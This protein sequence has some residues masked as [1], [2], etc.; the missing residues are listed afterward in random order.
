VCREAINIFAFDNFLARIF[1]HFKTK[2]MKNKFFY[3]GLFALSLIFCTCNKN[4]KTS[5]YIQ[6]QTATFS[7]SKK[8]SSKQAY[9]LSDAPETIVYSLLDGR[10]KFETEEDFNYF[11]NYL[12]EDE[13]TTW[14]SSIG[15]YSLY[16]TLPDE[17][18]YSVYATL[19]THGIIQ[20]GHYLFKLIP[21]YKK[22]LVMSD[23]NIA[24]LYELE[25]A[26]EGSDL[27]QAFSFNEEVFGKLEEQEGVYPT[28]VNIEK[29][30][31]RDRYAREDMKHG[32]FNYTEAGSYFRSGDATMHT[33]EFMGL[34]EYKKMGIAVQLVCKYTNNN[35]TIESSR[36]PFESASLKTQKT[37]FH[38]VFKY[39]PRCRSNVSNEIDVIYSDKKN[40]VYNVYSSTRDCKNYSLTSTFSFQSYYTSIWRREV[41]TINI[42]D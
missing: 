38:L 5:K 7:I 18:K 2:P 4:T 36:R 11:I 31:C 21:E 29:A 23:V 34:V 19:N 24:H 40:G 6:K 3:L 28:G 35:K 10:L 32:T 30:I 26:S 41:F 17:E 25:L 27:I 20:V 8:N 13:I 1:I 37:L 9:K 39:S 42:L 22:V 33:I 14:E 15:F 16:N 12:E